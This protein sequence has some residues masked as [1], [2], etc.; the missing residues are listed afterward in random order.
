MSA[1]PKDVTAVLTTRGDVN[2]Q[3]IIDTLPYGEVLVWDK[4]KRPHDYGVF[5]RYV[6]LSEVR[7]PLVY[8]QDD[9]CLCRSHD[10]LLEAWE[11]GHVVGNARPD[12]TRLARFHDTTLLGWG[13]IFDVELPSIAFAKYSLHY[14]ID[15][16]FR[17]FGAEVV[18]PML[19]PSKTVVREIDLLVEDGLDVAMRDNRMWRQHDFYPELE[20][21]LERAREVRDR[22]KNSA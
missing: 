12:A 22:L 21:W 8:F 16:R 3:P 20:F 18:F 10:L 13:A 4:T 17:S 19:T 6:A 5:S 15:D 11:P 14:P 7:T 1:D 9:D 2:L